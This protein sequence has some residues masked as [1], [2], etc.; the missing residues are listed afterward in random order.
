MKQLYSGSIMYWPHQNHTGNN[1]AHGSEI[2]CSCF[3]KDNL[4]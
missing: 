1:H 3:G 2:Q 4:F